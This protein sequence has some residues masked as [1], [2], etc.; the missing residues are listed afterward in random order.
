[1]E[2]KMNIDYK[3]LKERLDNVHAELVSIFLP[4]MLCH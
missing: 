3:E 4:V 2:T 1:M